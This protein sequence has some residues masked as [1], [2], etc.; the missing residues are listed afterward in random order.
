MMQKPAISSLLLLLCFLS[1]GKTFSQQ[2][3]IND[4]LVDYLRIIDTNGELETEASFLILPISQKGFTISEKKFTSWFEKLS[5]NSLSVNDKKKYHL[6]LYSPIYFQSYNS[7]LPSG[8]NDG[9]L[10]QGRGLNT[11]FSFGLWGNYKFLEFSIRPELIY[12]QNKSYE[13]SPYNI[14]DSLSEFSQYFTAIDTPQRFGID[15]HKSI[16]SGQSYLR[17][18][19]KNVSLGFSTANMWIGPSRSN[20]I[21]MS[22]NAKGFGHF[23]VETSRPILTTAGTIESRLYWGELSESDYFDNVSYNDKKFTS[24]FIL[25]YSPSFAKS[26]N[27]GYSRVF[28]KPRNNESYSYTDVFSLLKSFKK[29]DNRSNKINSLMFRWKPET[30]NEIYLEFAKNGYSIDSNDFLLEIEHSRAFTLGAFKT[31]NLTSNNFI[32]LN[33]EITQLENPKPGLFRDY[34]P[35]YSDSTGTGGYTH[36]GQ[37][38]GAAIGPGSNSQYL[39]LS[40]YGNWGG[41]SF[42]YNRIVYNNDQLYLNLPNIQSKNGSR[43]SL[44]RIHNVELR[45]GISST[46][47]FKNIELILNIWNSIEYNRYNL[48]END[49][50]NTH[51]DLTLRYAFENLLR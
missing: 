4:S 13:I 49:F 20:P 51:L 30:G 43:Y 29:S 19:T 50:F 11:S 42:F 39:G 10:W 22:N 38:L 27:L 34:E 15:E 40:Y 6:K 41:I 2:F 14:A 24:G 23:F 3:T 1:T 5:S 26:I 35:Y 32:M 31:I 9:A 44:R 48:Y 16:H 28:I 47:F 21:T 36:K 25:A 7:E 8:N 17:I 46:F 18:N 33:I 37:V 12:Y 45:G